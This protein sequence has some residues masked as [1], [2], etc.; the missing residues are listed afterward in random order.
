MLCELNFMTDICTLI[1][2][3]PHLELVVLLFLTDMELSRILKRVHVIDVIES[4][5]K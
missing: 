4:E 2:N 5:M 3:D 1:G